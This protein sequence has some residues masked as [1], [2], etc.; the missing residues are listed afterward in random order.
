MRLKLKPYAALN[1]ISGS[2]NTSESLFGNSWNSA[3]ISVSID[4]VA[5]D[6]DAVSVGNLVVATAIVFGVKL[7]GISPLSCLVTSTGSIVKL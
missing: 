7:E 6:S 4:T 5:L 2:E 3:G 1:F